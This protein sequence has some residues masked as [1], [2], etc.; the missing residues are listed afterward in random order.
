MNFNTQGRLSQIV[1]TLVYIN[2]LFWIYKNSCRPSNVIDHHNVCFFVIKNVDY[3][4]QKR[5][6]TDKR[7]NNSSISASIY[8]VNNLCK[9]FGLNKVQQCISLICPNLNLNQ[10]F[11]G[12]LLELLRKRNNK[13][14]AN[15]TLSHR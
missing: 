13:R 7:P 2:M 8:S 3:G 9:R 14:I 15:K 10:L 12:A 4:N 11:F 1:C 6:W 5:Q